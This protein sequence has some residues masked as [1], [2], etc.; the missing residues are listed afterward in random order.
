MASIQ[1]RDN[2]D[3][4]E[5]ARWCQDFAAIL[6]KPRSHQLFRDWSE[7]AAYDL[8][9][10]WGRTASEAAAEKAYRMEWEKYRERVSYYITEYYERS[11][12]TLIE[13]DIYANF[14]RDAD[15]MHAAILIAKRSRWNLV[16]VRG[17]S[18]SPLQQRI[19]EMEGDESNHAWASRI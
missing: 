8:L 3:P 12:N 9:S 7:N 17:G 14:A 11:V 1:S 13:L 4:I 15:E 6:S 5:I 16:K 2:A 18:I 10:Y 19:G